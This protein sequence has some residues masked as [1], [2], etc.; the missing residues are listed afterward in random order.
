[1][2]VLREREVGKEEMREAELQ[3]RLGTLLFTCTVVAAVFT[4]QSCEYSYNTC[5]SY[6][7]T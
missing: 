7:C 6:T 2:R 5:M 3:T 4:P 1:M